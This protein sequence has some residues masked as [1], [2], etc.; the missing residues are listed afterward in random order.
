MEKYTAAILKE[1]AGLRPD[2]K[3]VE[4]TPWL[5]A[6][7]WK[8][9][10]CFHSQKYD[11]FLAVDIIPSAA[12]P[13]SIYRSEVQP[14]LRNH[15]NLRAAVCVLESGLNSHPEV[16]EFCKELNI[17]LKVL[18][19][20]LGLETLLRT[21]L[22]PEVIEK[23][24]EQEPGWF[25]AAMLRRAKG[26]KKL[27]FSKD[28]DALIPKLED[29]RE[30]NAKTLQL[31]RETVDKLLPA[32]P[33]FTSNLRQFMRLEQFE[34][35]LKIA[36]PN[37]S[38]HVFHS[39]RVFLA[40]CPVINEF[41]PLFQSAQRCLLSSQDGELRPEYTWLLASI[42]HDIGRPKE[43]AS[44]FLED[45]IQDED[46]EVS[47]RGK[48][49]R[50]VRP[51]YQGARRL[52]GSLAVFLRTDRS[53]GARWDGG[54]IDDQEAEPLAIA[55]TRLYDEMRTHGVIGAMDFLAQVY[56]E[57]G[58]SDETE[59]RPLVLAH[60][61][62]ASLA[63]L[64]HD[65]RIWNE[66]RGWGLVPIDATRLPLA[67]LLVFLDTWD[68]YKRKEDQE[69]PGIVDYIVDAQG[70]CV[71]VEWGRSDLLEKERGKY[72]AFEENV[73]N[74]PFAM[75]IAPRFGGN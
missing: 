52:L 23:Q 15:A 71:T 36:S 10:I 47:V 49:S 40:G 65:W 4:P 51:E 12:I 75:K 53:S 70:A 33:T 20:G 8:P 6:S 16:E 59:N 17:G 28:L 13:R 35:L 63:I 58:A 42:F 19:P 2:L 73:V 30:E 55:W 21:D 62:P 26:L 66:A 57:A 27:F 9:H 74:K 64:C 56:K 39:F 29:A 45:T 44:H 18:V 5:A 14:L 3:K 41:Y 24:V 22:D 1:M 61:V 72:K 32:C 25:P 50:W 11:R 7:R 46:V 31:V 67:A 43:G 60:A 37:C 69:F 34:S 54:A 68:D 38:E 48:S